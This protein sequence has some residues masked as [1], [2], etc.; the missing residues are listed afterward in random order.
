MRQV[1]PPILGLL[2]I[3]GVLGLGAVACSNDGAAPGAPLFS[4]AQADSLSEQLAFDADDEIIGAT[5]SGDASLSAVAPTAAVRSSGTT[6]CTPTR[7]PPSPTD[8]DTDGVPDSVRLDFA[9][10]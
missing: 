2:A 4:Q 6:Q 1:R 5:T 8:T 10:C 3:A 9:G 7:S